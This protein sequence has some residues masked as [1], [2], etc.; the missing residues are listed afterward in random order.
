MKADNIEI[1]RK[2]LVSGDFKASAVEAFHIV[3]GYLSTSVGVT[4]RVRTKGDKAFLTIKGKT[5]YSGL[6]RYEW[7]KEIPAD[8]AAGLLALCGGKVI[9]KTRYMVPYG[10]HVYEVDEFHGDNLGL[11]MAEVELSSEDEEFLKP[12]WLGE[13]VTGDER[14]YNSQLRHNPV[15]K[16]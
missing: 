14:Y 3:Q 9:D 2:F 1:E 13:E 5:S 15:S 11:V 12:E 8:E 7:E 4:V 10:E 16:W 6:S